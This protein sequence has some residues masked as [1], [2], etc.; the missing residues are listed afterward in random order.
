MY[1]HLLL[2]MTLLFLL[3]SCS[4]EK[5]E[6]LEISTTTWIGY[7]PLFY[8]KEKGWLKPLNIK[9]MHVS[10]L[11]ENMYLY[12]AGNADAYVGTQYE[13]NML[14]KKEPSLIPVMLFDRSNGG[15]V[16]MSNLSIE[17]LQKSTEPINAYLEM[18][19]VN[20]T[21]LE[22]FIQNYNLHEKQINYINRDQ[23]SI[24]TLS[25]STVKNAIIVTYIPYDIELNKHGFKSIASTKDNLNLLVIDAMFTTEKTFSKHQKQFSELKK[26]VDRAV[27]VLEKNPREFYKMVKPYLLELNYEE[28]IQSTQDIEWINKNISPELKQ[29]MKESHFPTIGLI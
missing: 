12:Q 10:S 8:A 11:S 4:S 25:S 19:S 16:V 18:D 23:T 14:I 7:S 15:D 2:F 26:L 9:L 6:K 13:Y 22:D 29:R 28:F 21:L 27:D 5:Q 3:T 17:E 24:S 1:K 20:S